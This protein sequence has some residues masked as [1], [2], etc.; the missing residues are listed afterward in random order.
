M[1]PRE[2]VAARP[3]GTRV[4]LAATMSG[5]FRPEPE[6]KN[7]LHPLKLFALLEAGHKNLTRATSTPDL[8]AAPVVP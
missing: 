3:S 8:A 1:S 5:V 4:V 2:R 6:F 7:R